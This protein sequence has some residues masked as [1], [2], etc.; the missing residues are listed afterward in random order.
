MAS[1]TTLAMMVPVRS[2]RDSPLEREQ[3]VEP[4]H[5]LVGGA[6]GIRRR[7]AKRH[8]GGRLPDGEHCIGVVGVDGEQHAV[9]SAVDREDLAGRDAPELSRGVQE[10]RTVLIYVEEPA[11]QGGGR[12]P[13][14]DRLA[15]R[16]RPR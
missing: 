10:Q 5:V 4:D 7:R 14:A 8:A 11:M 15:E 1:G 16:D 2:R 12:Q 6:P 9:S 13:H 3:M